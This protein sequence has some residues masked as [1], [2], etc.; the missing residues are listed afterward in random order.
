MRLTEMF[1]CGYGYITILISTATVCGI[2]PRTRLVSQQEPN[3]EEQDK[4]IG[5]WLKPAFPLQ[6][7]FNNL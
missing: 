3:N 2:R 7:P 1:F 4:H 6:Q 5:V